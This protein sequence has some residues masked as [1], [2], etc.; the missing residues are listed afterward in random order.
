VLRIFMLSWEYPPRIIGGLS[1]H[2]DGLSKALANMGHEVHVVT[3]DF[4]ETPYEEEHG[5]LYIHRVGVDIPTPTFHTW[6]LLFNHFFEKRT[7]QLAKKYGAPD[8]VHTHDWLTV[9]GGVAAKHL[10]RVPLVMTFHS[11][12]A[13][14]SSNSPSPESAMVE[15]LEWWG[16]FE[17]ARV[18]A[19]S[20]WM[21]SEVVP[22]FQIPT[23]KVAEIPNAVDPLKFEGPIDTQAIR[24]R[25]KVK[26]GERLITAVGR[27]T[28]QK[29]FDDLIRAYPAIRRAIPASRLLLM[30]D[31]YMRG[32]LES[33]AEREQVRENTTFTGFVSDSDL[34]GALKSSDVVVVPSRFEPFG[35]IALEAMASGVPVVVSRVGGL[36]EIVEDTVDGLEVEP[37]SPASIAE[38][39]VKVLSDRAFASRLAEKGREKAKVYSWENAARRTLE[40][41]QEAERE[42]K[43]E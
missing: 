20:A 43:Y 17:A 40:A 14:R 19:V 15:G 13:S 31:G 35:I 42:S 34:I 6:V 38:A 30:G 10:L 3:L 8:I 28:S 24:E 22:M 4:P 39:T 5:S 12:E 23:Y 37:N 18:I 29:G 41:Y 7:G 9:S 33:L 1:R 21:K 11:T 32:E 27:F 2:V 16:S 26:E 36:A 25:W